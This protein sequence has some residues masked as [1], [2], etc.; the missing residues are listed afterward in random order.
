[1]IPARLAALQH[2]RDH[3]SYWHHKINFF[4]NISYEFSRLAAI[5][6]AHIRHS[7]GG[8]ELSVVN[9][10]LLAGLHE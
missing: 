4:L 9:G 8:A 10:G 3:L 1:M 6:S 7:T 2:Y 5:R